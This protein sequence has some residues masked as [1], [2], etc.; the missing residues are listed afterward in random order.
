MASARQRS[1]AAR[2]QSARRGS[3]RTAP[4]PRTVRV[5]GPVSGIR[6]DRLARLA[7]LVVFVLVA[8]VA[9]QGIMSFIR[10]RSE[11]TQQ[12]AV[13]QALAREHR[14]LAAQDRALRQPATIVSDARSL[15]MVR[16]GEQ[17]FVVTGLPHR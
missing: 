6:W 8:G 17:P 7:L 5:R 9:I 16:V 13:V 15:G 3:G 4:R 11:A 2:A 12:V 1:A 14:R 10:T